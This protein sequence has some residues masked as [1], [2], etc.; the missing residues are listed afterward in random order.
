MTDSFWYNNPLILLNKDYILEVMPKQGMSYERKMNSITRLIIYFTSL[1]YIF[2]TSRKLIIG[3]LAILL[4][5]IIL[6]KVRQNQI[7]NEGFNN[8]SD[9]PRVNS[10]LSNS[11]NITNPQTLET[12]SKHEFKEGNK[13][14]P[15][16]NVLLTDIMDDPDRNAAPP[17]FNPQIDETITKNIKKSVQHMNPGIKNTNKQLFSDLT[18]N[19]YLDQSNRAFYSTANTRVSNDQGAFGEFLYGNMPSPKESN[20]GGAIQRV[21]DSYRYTLY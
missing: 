6:Y 15:F 17:S 5:I 20:V 12:F 4:F 9:Q 21:K 1:V 10:S 8:I 16:S 19:F 7:I 11:D 13:K 18:D 14:N 2:T 3:C